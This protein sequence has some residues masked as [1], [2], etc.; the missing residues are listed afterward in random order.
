M[1][2]GVVLVLTAPI[3]VLPWEPCRVLAVLEIVH[4]LEYLDSSTIA[5]LE[6][7]A[8]EAAKTLFGLIR[9]LDRR[10]TP[11]HSG[12]ITTAAGRLTTPLST[13]D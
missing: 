5:R 12:L 6:A 1:S 8:D 4:E 13:L 2:P 7:R 3:A 10:T 9:S 11:E